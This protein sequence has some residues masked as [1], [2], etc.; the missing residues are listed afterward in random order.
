MSDESLLEFSRALADAVRS[1]LPLG[2]TL[3]SLS[4]SPGYGRRLTAAAEMV[5]AGKPL[6][7]SL[8]AQ[9]VFPPLFIAVIRA[10]EESGKLDEFIDRFSAVLE[11]EIDL[12]RRIR[13]AL[14][15]PFFAVLLAAA[16]FVFFSTVAAPLLLQ[17]LIDSGAA[18]NAGAGSAL[19]AGRFIL[20]HWVGLMGWIFAAALAL[21]AIARTRPWRT[22]WA[23]AGHWMPGVRFAL[24]EARFHRIQSTMELLL[25]AGLRP[26]ELI[27]LLRQIFRDDP[28][29]SRRLE[30]GAILLS[31]GRSFTE[32]VG[33]CLPS[34]ERIRVAVA[35]RAGRLDEAL[36]ALARAHFDRHLHRLKL[37][38]IALKIGAVAALAPLCFGLVLWIVWPALSMLGPAM[39][40]SAEPAGPAAVRATTPSAPP[41]TPETARFN[42]AGAREVV[43]FMRDHG[44]AGPSKPV[45]MP[46]LKPAASMRNTG[47]KSIQPTDIKSSFDR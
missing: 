23:V 44:A 17:P 18:V 40:V 25:G 3:R 42:A 16:V 2:E 24:E 31:E 28:V 14:A 13:Q 34:D 32:S 1:G 29:T 5:G 38:T 36:G 46:H 8:A 43:D 21:R 4:R 11:T 37:L 27:D 41:E 22:A 20:A 7:E 9:K 47:F 6:H 12:R 35:E 26:R 39:T 10:G 19:G 15:Y 30:R 33:D 45:P